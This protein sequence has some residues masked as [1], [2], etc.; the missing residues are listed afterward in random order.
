MLRVGLTGGIACGKST[1][2]AMMRELGCYIIEADPLAHK[3]IEP[4]R[5]AFQEVI[6]AFG[7]DVLRPDGFVDRKKLGAIVF[8]DI[9]KLLRL[10]AI[11][12]P[13]VLKELEILFSDFAAANP[14]GIAVVEAALLIEAGYVKHLDK[15]IVAWCTPE[16]QMERLLA[17]GMTR[18]QIE[19]R[20]AAQ[21]P[22]E[23][24]RRRADEV[25]DC[26][27]TLE[28]TRKQVEC[29]VARLQDLAA[30]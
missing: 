25:V 14:R 19:Q 12:H 26:S 2:A 9:D 16:Q 24:K 18:E 13:R 4:G 7:I 1:V 11:V 23:E 8:A 29:L 30:A 20:V 3:L 28:E 21:M 22:M 5:P 10:N 27:V 17:R 6:R 15:L